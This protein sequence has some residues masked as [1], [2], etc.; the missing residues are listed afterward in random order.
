MIKNK[1][2]LFVSLCL[3]A[4]GLTGN[5]ILDATGFFSNPSTYVISI[6]IAS[7]EGYFL[8]GLLVLAITLL[9]L[10]V[11]PFTL[12]R[13]KTLISAMFL[14]VVILIPQLV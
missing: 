4:I 5:L 9:G 6:P 12:N 2:I 11:L 7:N 13:N 3:I 10:F 1:T 14:S 8:E